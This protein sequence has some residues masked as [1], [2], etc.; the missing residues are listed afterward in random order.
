MFVVVLGS[1]VP[2]PSGSAGKER[3]SGPPSMLQPIHGWLQT[4][5]GHG[6]YWSSMG[7]NRQASNTAIVETF[8]DYPVC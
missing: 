8:P 2:A 5:L 1:A 6:E 3:K 4:Y 7:K